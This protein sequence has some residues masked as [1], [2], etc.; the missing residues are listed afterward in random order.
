LSIDEAVTWRGAVVVGGA[1]HDSGRAVAV[2]DVAEIVRPHPSTRGGAMDG[3]AAVG[4]GDVAAGGRGDV[5]CRLASASAMGA[6]SL[7][8]CGHSRR[9]TAA[10]MMTAGM[11]W[12][13]VEKM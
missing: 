9:G 2:S 5:A 13:W 11:G 7:G 10:A 12:W 1:W 4:R 6:P 3:D 8:P